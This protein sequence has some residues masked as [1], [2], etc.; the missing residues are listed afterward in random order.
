MKNLVLIGFIAA[1]AANASQII[2]PPGESANFIAQQAVNIT[3]QKSDVPF[4]SVARNNNTSSYEVWIGNSLAET[5]LSLDSAIQV[6]KEL[7]T[8]GLCRLAN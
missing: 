7:N 6:A 3:C 1:A 2:L 8:A 5:T 4:C